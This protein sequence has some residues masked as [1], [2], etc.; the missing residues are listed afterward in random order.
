[1]RTK[2]LFVALAVAAVC[3]AKDIKT[4]VLNTA[5][6][7]HCSSCENKIKSN[8][9]F[10]KGI[11]DI[12]TNLTDK[13]VTITYDA[14]KTNVEKIIAGFK[15]IDYVATVAGSEAAA[16]QAEEK[17]GGCCGSG[18]CKCGQ[19]KEEAEAKPAEKKGCSCCSSKTEAEAPVA[20]NGSVVKYKASQM[21][22]GGC[23]N[24]VKTLLS[25]I[26]GVQ[27][28]AVNLETKV[29]TVNYDAQKTD[30]AK[31]KDSFK[32]INYTVEDVQ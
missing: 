10:E 15:K 22:C 31:I 1:M 17:Q 8:I 32:T 11:K 29:V 12:Q 21:S 19:K 27:D 16:P 23:A 9:K 18:G 24:K 2:V 7:M 3:N 4:V 5:P 25:G 30:A 28:V 6:E 20:V 13:T 26:E 14:D